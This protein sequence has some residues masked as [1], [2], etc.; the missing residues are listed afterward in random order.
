MKE[1]ELPKQKNVNV[2]VLLQKEKGK[3]QPEEKNN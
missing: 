2:N 3:Q 1:S